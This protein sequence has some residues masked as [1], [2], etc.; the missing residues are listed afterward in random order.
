MGAD[1]VALVFL[2]AIRALL[3]DHINSED[4]SAVG[5]YIRQFLWRARRAARDCTFSVAQGAILDGPEA[6]FRKENQAAV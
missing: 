1:F 2:A 6:A 5:S 4:A 3:A